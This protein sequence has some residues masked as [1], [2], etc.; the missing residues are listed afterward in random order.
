M[1]APYVVE[2]D[3]HPLG[4]ELQAVLGDSTGRRT[5]PNILV[6][7]KSIGGGDDIASQDESGQLAGKLK[8]MGGKWIVDVQLS[9]EA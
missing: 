6:N 3:Q 2:L 1:P 4:R 5:V 8:T 9:Q 7:A